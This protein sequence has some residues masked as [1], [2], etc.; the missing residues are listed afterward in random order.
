VSPSGT[1]NPHQPDRQ[2]GWVTETAEA[3]VRPVKRL[4]VRCRQQDGEFASGVLISALS[5]QHVL[6]LTDQPLSLLDNPAAV[7]LA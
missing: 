6:V 7:L 2:F 5:A 1:S 3:Y 4:A